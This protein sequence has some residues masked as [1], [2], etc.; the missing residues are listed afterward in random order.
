MET[1][2]LQYI[3][4]GGEI[5]CDDL[6]WIFE[7]LV[8][9]D[10]SLVYCYCS[11]NLSWKSRENGDAKKEEIYYFRKDFTPLQIYP[12]V[13]LLNVLC[14]PWWQEKDKGGKTE[15]KVSTY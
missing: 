11:T 4:Q 1:S 8:A 6:I 13:T 10:H 3:S 9:T 2:F 5:V 12:I 14:L 15:K 7:T